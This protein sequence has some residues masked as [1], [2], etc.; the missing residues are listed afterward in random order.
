SDLAELERIL[1]ESGV[2]EPDEIRRA[3]D[4]AHGLGL[5]VRSLVG[6]D[7]AAAKE[8]LANF[9]ETRTLTANQLE[10]VNLIVDHLTE[11][12]V[13]EPARLYESP[14]TDLTPQGPDRLFPSGELDA[15]I[16]AIEG[17]RATAVAA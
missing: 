15:L 4:A 11:H 6:M 13:I 2:G 9:I 8:V 16:R 3:A 17:A 5:F 12:G 14:F 7:R 1:A 10:F